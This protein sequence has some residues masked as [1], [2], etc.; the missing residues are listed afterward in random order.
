MTRIINFL[1]GISVRINEARGG[2]AGCTVCA[3]LWEARLRGC[4][5]SSKL[6]T[7]VDAIFFWDRQHCR[8][9]WL[10]T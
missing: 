3:D 6:V 10:R 5:V 4:P 8:S 1:R 7:V 9:A 2:R